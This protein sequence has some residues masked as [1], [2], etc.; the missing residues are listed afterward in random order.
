MRP[1]LFLEI[2]KESV[3]KLEPVPQ[4]TITEHTITKAPKGGLKS[5]F[6]FQK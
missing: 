4:N 6:S 2:M 3:V 1:F 5:I